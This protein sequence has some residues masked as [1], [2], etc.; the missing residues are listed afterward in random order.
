MTLN[1]LNF[2][3]V[4]NIKDFFLLIAYLHFDVN[5]RRRITICFLSF[6]I[7]GGNIKA[8]ISRAVCEKYSMDNTNSFTL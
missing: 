8:F 2:D 5:F 7:V 1:N 4:T 6:D 3:I